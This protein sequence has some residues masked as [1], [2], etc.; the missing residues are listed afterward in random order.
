MCRVK[1]YLYG[2]VKVSGEA[3]LNE[4]GSEVQHGQQQGLEV[5]VVRPVAHQQP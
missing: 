1:T 5:P 3:V 4:Q 2:A